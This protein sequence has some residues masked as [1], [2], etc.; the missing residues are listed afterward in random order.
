[1]DTLAAEWFGR[2]DGLG[3]VWIRGGCSTPYD[4]LCTDT[5]GTNCGGVG[6]DT[7]A[8]ENCRVSRCEAICVADSQCVMYWD[9]YT[10]PFAGLC[11]FYN[12]PE[13]TMVIVGGIPDN[14]LHKK[15]LCSLPPPPP[16]AP[17][18]ESGSGP[19]GPCYSQLSTGSTKVYCKFQWAH[20]YRENIHEFCQSR[21][22]E[23][24]HTPMAA[25]P[26]NPFSNDELAFGH[27]TLG[28][29]FT[30]LP[31]RNPA[32]QRPMEDWAYP[33]DLA[34]AG[35]DDFVQC[36]STWLGAE[37]YPFKGIAVLP[38]PCNSYPFWCIVDDYLPPSSPPFSPIFSTS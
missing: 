2:P 22:T 13:S 26:W 27:A 33:S 23:L 14:R 32:D 29:G 7:N 20:S 30:V 34:V 19:I 17:A 21:M 3:Y 28:G 9:V 4:L 18:T 36:A 35:N 1:M 31:S 38:A 25:A 24:G 5:E 8:D 6:D 10:G 37:S 15:V 16:F 11:S 12:A